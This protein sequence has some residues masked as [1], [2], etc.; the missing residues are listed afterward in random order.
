MST[1][2]GSEP[3]PGLRTSRRRFLQGALVAGGTVTIGFPSILRARTKTLKIAALY[4]M[5]GFAQFY[6]SYYNEG[7]QLA[8][9]EMRPQLK[10]LQVEHTIYDT[11]SNPGVAV[12]KA[13]EALERGAH[14]ID[15]AILASTATA[16]APIASGNRV[17]MTTGTGQFELFG[18]KCNRY[19]FKWN[20]TNFTQMR[21]PFIYAL[22]SQPDLKKGKWALVT[23]N[24]NWGKQSRQV[25]LDYIKEKKLPISI[26][27]DSLY[28]PK[29]S[30]FTSHLNKARVQRPNALFWIGIGAPAT[31]NALKQ[32]YQ[33]GLMQEMRV[34]WTLGGL[35]PFQNCGSQVIQNT[36][37]NLLWWHTV[38]APL[39]QEF[40]AR[41]KKKYNKTPDWY[42]AVGY[43]T[44]LM[45]LK[46][47]ATTQSTAAKDNIQA[48]EQWQFEGLTGPE[49]MNPD[50]HVVEKP[51]YAAVGKKPAEK[52]Y[53]DDWVFLH[54][55]SNPADITWTQD[56]AQC[57]FK[58]KV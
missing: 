2:D 28:D 46:T 29:A 34:L 18:K 4:C 57:H 16:L 11:Q 44:L 7:A 50:T 5:S 38:D 43:A 52:R 42:H 36:I 21:T 58:Q 12:R 23:V 13:H 53:E 55:V 1:F 45:Y 10:G 37:T 33:M 30:D 19:V 14:H 15:G 25:V 47:V 49:R 3:I 26:V 9:E 17:T 22:E 27:E 8:L 32:A 48:L 56:R 51:H 40:T 41:F 35:N 54:T 6:G 39:S 24:Y 31:I 20:A